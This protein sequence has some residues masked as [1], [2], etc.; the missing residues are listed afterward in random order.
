[1]NRGENYLRHELCHQCL[2]YAR[3][4]RDVGIPF[5]SVMKQRLQDYLLGLLDG[6]VVSTR[7]NKKLIAEG[8][9]EF[10]GTNGS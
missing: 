1:M 5:G 8:I 4:L 2:H 9:K 3:F 7:T 10:R 6:I